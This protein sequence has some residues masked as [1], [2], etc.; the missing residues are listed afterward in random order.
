M[1]LQFIFYNFPISSLHPLNVPYSLQKLVLSV[2]NHNSCAFYV[3]LYVF[4]SL[5]NYFDLI[6]WN[7]PLKNTLVAKKLLRSFHIRVE[8]LIMLG[9]FLI[10]LNLGCLVFQSF[11]VLFS[12][13]FILYFLF[14]FCLFH[15]CKVSP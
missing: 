5:R 14:T 12:L 8:N 3:M 1:L 7:F 10:V 11:R 6:R 4:Y 2:Q 13:L 9:T 15:L